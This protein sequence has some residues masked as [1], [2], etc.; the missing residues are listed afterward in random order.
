MHHR[1]LPGHGPDH[2]LWPS[3]LLRQ[4]LQLRVRRGLHL[5]QRGVFVA[6]KPETNEYASF[7]GSVTSPEPGTVTVSDINNGLTM[8]F[9]VAAADEDGNVV[10]D[11]GEQ[12]TAV[13]AKCDPSEVVNAIAQIGTYGDAVA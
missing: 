8:T 1:H 4:R 9:S 10:I 5:R 11:M 6:Y 3:G 12:G 13:L 2:V 7:V